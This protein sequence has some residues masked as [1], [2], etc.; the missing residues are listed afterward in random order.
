MANGDSREVKILKRILRIDEQGL[1]WEADPR[2][3]ELL[4]K[5]LGLENCSTISTPGVKPKDVE[6]EDADA[7]SEPDSPPPHDCNK[8]LV[9]ATH[10]RIKPNHQPPRPPGPY[11]VTFNDNIETININRP[12]GS[13]YGVHPSKIVFIGEVG[14]LSVKMVPEHS[15]PFTGNSQIIMNDRCDGDHVHEDYRLPILEHAL[16]E[17]SAWEP[18]SGDSLDRFVAATIPN[19]KKNIYK[20]RLGTKAVKECEVRD[21]VGGILSDEQATNFRALAA[22]ANYLALD[23]PDVA[24]SC[25]ELRRAF[26]KPTEDVRALKRCVRYL[27]HNPRLIR[28]YQWG[29]GADCIDIYADTDF[30]GC[31]RTRRSTSGG[32]AHN[33]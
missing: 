29:R 32:H 22:R 31:R 20:K 19:A 7:E 9:H 12:Y 10:R 15:D 11:H 21:A 33:G 23:R 26:S 2:H 27:V 1:K 8:P 18:S 4:A 3:T 6:L 17:G 13:I 14:D 30:A 25:K 5:P 24:F 28:H 16:R